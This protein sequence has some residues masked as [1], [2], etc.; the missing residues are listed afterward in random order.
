MKDI[1]AELQS[2]KEEAEQ[3]ENGK[4]RPIY[5][6]LQGSQNYKLETENSDID[7]KV[8]TLPSLSQIIKNGKPT[9]FT[10]VRDNNE[11]ID[12][13]DVRLMFECFKKQNINFIEILFTDYYFV[14][15]D[16]YKSLLEELRSHAEE[17]AVLNPYRAIKCMK[18]MALEKYNALWHPY[19]AKIDIINKYGYDGKQLHHLLRIKYFLDDYICM[20]GD[21]KG[22]KLLYKE[23]L[24]S[25]LMSSGLRKE[26]KLIKE[27]KVYQLDEAK[28]V[29]ERTLQLITEKANNACDKL[30]DENNKETEKLLDNILYEIVKLA[31]KE[32]LEV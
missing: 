32:E 6:A 17:I 22:I 8:I 24:Q 28:D 2:H 5:I 12:M 29:A 19:P 18:G 10:H 4:Y 26:L 1:M 11:H 20:L 3:L 27:N 9:S 7:T 14:M 25:E 13:K 30:K 31:L 16:K 23:I 15:N 21:Y